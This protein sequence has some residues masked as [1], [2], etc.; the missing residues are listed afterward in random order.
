MK[1][2]TVGLFVMLL[3]VGVAGCGGEERLRARAAYDMKCDEKSLVLTE[4]G[5]TSFGVEGCGQRQVYVCKENRRPGACGDWV[6]NSVDSS[7]SKDSS[8][9]K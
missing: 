3:G 9:S 5:E 8:G 4:L 1:A 6:L 7:D 2:S